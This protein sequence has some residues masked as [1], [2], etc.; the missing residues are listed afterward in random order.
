MSSAQPYTDADNDI[1]TVRE[2]VD[3]VEIRSYVA[4]LGSDSNFVVSGETWLKLTN[5]VH[6]LKIVATD[7]FDS[8]TRTF[9]FTKNVSM[10]VVERKVPITASTQPK[11]II[12]TVVK[13]I[14]TEAIFKV[15]A[16]NN[17]FDA[18]PTW[19]DITSDVNRGEIYDFTNTD[20]TAEQWGVN[21]RVTVDRNGAEGA[22]YITEIGGNFE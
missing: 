15:E 18:S 16:C 4:T 19:E 11:S 3:N 5:G 22:C 12:V 6:T 9:T 7:G 10:L 2:Y 21:I 13:N 17:G 1:V 14:P 8:V 20:K